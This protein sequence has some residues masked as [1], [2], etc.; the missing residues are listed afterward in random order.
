MLPHFIAQH[1][2]CQLLILITA[3]VGVGGELK[4]SIRLLLFT[5]LRQL[6][7]ILLHVGQKE[8]LCLLE[9]LVSLVILQVVV[10]QSVCVEGEESWS[11]LELGE[12]MLC[13]GL[14]TGQLDCGC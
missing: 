4:H 8:L 1:L 6:L 9:R 11:P 14:E 13:F 5:L 3:A 7:P 12:H 2:Q 10:L